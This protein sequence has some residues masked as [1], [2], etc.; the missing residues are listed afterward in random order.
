MFFSFRWYRY[1]YVPKKNDYKGFFHLQERT[2]KIPVVFSR[3]NQFLKP[4]SSKFSTTQ[5]SQIR[6]MFRLSKKW[7]SG[8]ILTN[9][10]WHHLAQPIYFHAS[11]WE[12]TIRE[13]SLSYFSVCVCVCVSCWQMLECSVNDLIILK[14]MVLYEVTSS[15]SMECQAIPCPNKC[16]CHITDWYLSPNYSV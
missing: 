15:D 12:S 6:N 10:S 8:A 16:R 2:C 5:K 11:K 14:L 13:N 4:N 9:T 3:S 1:Q 7:S